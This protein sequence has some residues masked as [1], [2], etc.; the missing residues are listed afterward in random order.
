MNQNRKTIVKLHTN[1]RYITKPDD[2]L[3]S[4]VNLYQKL[5]MTK[6]ITITY[7]LTKFPGSNLSEKDKMHCEK[8]I[9]PTEVANTIKTLKNQMS[10]NRFFTNRILHFLL[11]RYSR[12]V[13]EYV[14]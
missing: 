10:R 8:Q 2:I 11:V 5:F 3:N 13:H 7:T 1:N 12:L 6:G 9:T 4:F 14:V